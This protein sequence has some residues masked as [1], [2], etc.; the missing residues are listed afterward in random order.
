MG[1]DLVPEP[2]TG[3]SEMVRFLGCRRERSQSNGTM[4]ASKEVEAT[5]NEIHFSFLPVLLR[6][7]IYVWWDD[8][9][10]KLLVIDL[11][12]EIQI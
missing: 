2:K 7:A 4:T 12:E 3:V 10:K 9:I 1:G 5:P 8:K 6:N 11:E